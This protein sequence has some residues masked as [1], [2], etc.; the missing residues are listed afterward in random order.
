VLLK[1]HLCSND[2]RSFEALEWNRNHKYDP[3]SSRIANDGEHLWTGD[4]CDTRV[5]LR[6]LIEILYLITELICGHKTRNE[7]IK[8]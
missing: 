1:I 2:K 3:Y 5:Q 8:K 7:L 4:G 6:L